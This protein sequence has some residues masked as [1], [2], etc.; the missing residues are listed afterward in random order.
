MYLNRLIFQSF[1][2]ISA[3]P[4]TSLHPISSGKTP[5]TRLFASKIDSALLNKT[6]SLKKQFNPFEYLTKYTLNK[7]CDEK[8]TS[9]PRRLLWISTAVGGATTFCY[10]LKNSQMQANHDAALEKIWPEIFMQIE[11]EEFPV[12]FKADQIRKWLNDPNNAKHIRSVASLN[13]NHCKLTSLPP[14]I[15][16]FTQL[17]WLYLSGNRLTS[18]PQEITI[19]KELYALDL[20]RNHFSSRPSEID[21]LAKL[22]ILDLSDNH[23]EI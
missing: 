14:E 18:L 1:K 9:F 23:M 21:H 13:L 3:L 22:K 6:A 16:L 12:D 8:A 2:H 11:L 5:L 20:S 19:L 10:Y 17:K 4:N 15:T 7:E